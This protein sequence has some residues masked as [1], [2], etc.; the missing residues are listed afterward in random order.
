[1]EEIRKILEEIKYRNGWTTPAEFLFNQTAVFSLISRA[2]LLK[3]DIVS[4][5]YASG[6]IGSKETTF[7]SVLF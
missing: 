2:E 7:E 6:K 1:M 4:F 5:T 3:S